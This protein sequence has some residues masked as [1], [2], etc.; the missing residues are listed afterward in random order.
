MENQY[1][2]ND[3]QQQEINIQDY[4]NVLYHGRWVMLASFILVLLATA[5]YTF[6]AK[7]VYQASSKILVEKQGSMEQA[8]FESKYLNSQSTDIANQIEVLRSRTLAERV[9]LALEAS[10]YRDSLA[11]FQPNDNGEYMVLRQQVNWIL[12]NMAIAPVPETDIIR[13]TFSAGSA[14]EAAFICNTISEA[15]Q[16]LNREF[17][18]KEFRELRR[19]LEFQLK[20]KSEELRQSEEALRAYQENEKLVSIDSRT[21]ELISQLGQTQGA[22]EAT[23]VEMEG[24]QEQKKN[25]EKQLEEKR[26]QMPVE[27]TQVSSPLLNELQQEYARLVNEKVK[28]EAL[29][30]QDQAIDPTEYQNELQGQSMRIR[31]VQ[32]R[33]EEE[34][35]RIATT[36]MV[37]NPL[38]VVQILI[39]NILNAET[40]IKGY[41]AKVSALRDVVD[42]YERELEQLP[43]Q[44]LE[45][46]RLR[47][48]LEVDQTTYLLLNQKREET[49]IVEA[50]QKEVVRSIDAAIE[51][52]EP[53]SPKKRLNLMLGAVLGL[54]L[55]IGLAFLR[56]FFDDS[57]KNPE[58][59]EQMGFNILSVIPQIDSEDP[60][61]LAA[62]P[63][64]N[65][66][67]NGLLP[68]EGTVQARL[69]TH[70]DPK[71]PI[72]E[73]YRTL[74]TNI[75]FQKLQHNQNALMVTSST[76][77]E[78]KS[79]TISNLA[80][81][82]AQM[83][84]RTLIVDTDLRRP[85][86]HS[87]FNLKKDKGVTNFL[88][89]KLTFDEV[90]KPT[91]VDNLS[92]ITSGPLPPNPSEL[93]SSPE[94]NEFIRLARE[95]F[96]VVLFD[97]PPIIAVTDAAILSTKVDGLI[98]V[99]KAHQTEKNAVKRAKTLLD[100]VKANI[101][102]CL[103]NG[104]NVERTYGSYYYQYYQYYSYYGHDLKRRSKKTK[105][106]NG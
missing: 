3:V 100:N 69:V 73:A 103:L 34:A 44:G 39:T 27:V 65:G 35:Q 71:S 93:L 48:Q 29:I 72:S 68:E 53:I 38:E 77:K 59:L 17:N 57:I 58:V 84:S 10:P 89:G 28:Y 74:R 5:V 15:Y 45:L 70:L 92:I 87:I 47:R 55:G 98:M 19:F 33:L 50:G 26:E 23:M 41:T 75:Q 81:T 88:M 43:G 12:Y 20:K 37:S 101:V 61:K 62:T 96:D 86:I 95:K 91:V 64:K 24:A 99:V 82:M 25:L 1:D 52:Q 66:S 56:E 18:L 21:N 14:F 105:T 104:V 94:M 60:T 11:I 79:T 30:A 51:P 6:T 63:Q 46:A 83:G 106:V 76:P 4:L 67:V 54:A 22:L 16:N 49:R 78:G 85:V 9:V 7:P 36:S 2:V 40:Q 8:L 32:R 90:L 102:G 42:S 31:A 13:V 80:I 97:S